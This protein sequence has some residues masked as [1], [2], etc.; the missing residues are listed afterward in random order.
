LTLNESGY[1]IVILCSR[2]DLAGGIERAVVNCANLFQSKGNQV[3][4]LILDET[5]QC[6]YPLHPG[7]KLHQ[8]PLSFGISATGN[9]I[10]RKIRMLSDVLKLR[11]ILKALH[12]TVVIATEYPFSA[13]AVLSGVRKRCKLVSWEHHHFNELEKNAF[14]KK[15]FHYTYP[16][17]HQIVCLNPDEKELYQSLNPH[18]VVIP[19]Y[20]EKAL[21]TSTC[22]NPL[23]LTVARLNYVKGIDM[24]IRVASMV[25]SRNPSWQW[26]VIGHGRMDKFF[27]EHIDREGLH[28]RLIIQEPAGPDLADEYS[29]ASLFVMTSRNECF[30]MTLLEAMSHGLPCIA[31][32]CETGPRHLV[33]NGQNGFLVNMHDLDTMADQITAL[34]KNETERKKMGVVSKNSVQEFSA[35]NI[36]RLWQDKV[37]K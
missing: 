26:K 7:I 34:I 36:Y 4:L 17:L 5:I 9:P 24:L 22:E 21:K 6:F 16:R 13:A 12:P 8:Q 30:P 1:H 2:L 31:F 28:E 32:N 11:K 29:R 25:L 18:T 20:A 27:K 37:F 14:W 3:T 33:R 15:V 23:I 35:D 10:S 19:N